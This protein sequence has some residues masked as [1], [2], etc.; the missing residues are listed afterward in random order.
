[1]CVYVYQCGVCVCQRLT[2]NVFLYYSIIKKKERKEKKI[3]FSVRLC[4]GTCMCECRCP[5]SPEEKPL[6]YVGREL[7]AGVECQH[8][9]W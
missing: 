7:Q 3:Y 4:V 5:G 6:D 8:R 9:F 2:L 1:M